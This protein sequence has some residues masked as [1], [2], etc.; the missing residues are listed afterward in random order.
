[1]RK[2]SQ[3]VHVEQ[4]ELGARRHEI[5]AILTYY[6][7]NPERLTGLMIIAELPNGAYEMKYTGTENVAERLGRLQLLMEQILDDAEEIIHQ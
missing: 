6:L 5:T 4:V 1:M 2:I 7:A 3:K